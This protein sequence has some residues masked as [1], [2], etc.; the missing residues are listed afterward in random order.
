MRYVAPFA[1]YIHL[2]N[3]LDDYKQ[4]SSLGLAGA[5]KVD[6]INEIFNIL[7]DTIESIFQNL[8]K[9]NNKSA[10]TI[11]NVLKGAYDVFITPYQHADEIHKSEALL[12]FIMEIF[13][14]EGLSYEIQPFVDAENLHIHALALMEA[15]FQLS[16]DIA[17][18]SQLNAANNNTTKEVSAKENKKFIDLPDIQRMLV[19]IK[20]HIYAARAMNFQVKLFEDMSH[21]RLSDN[22]TSNFSEKMI[23]KIENSNAYTDFLSP[24]L[25]GWVNDRALELTSNALQLLS[26][27]DMNMGSDLTRLYRDAGAISICGKTTNE[28]AL[29]FV[30]NKIAM[31]EAEIFRAIIDE[32]TTLCEIHLMHEDEDIS[33]MIDMLDT[34]KDD[35][36]QASEWMY[37]KVHL[38]DQAEEAYAGAK[39]FLHLW[40]MVYAGYCLIKIC[41]DGLD[42]VGSINRE[43]KKIAKYYGDNILVHS[44]AYSFSC[45]RGMETLKA[46]TLWQKK[47]L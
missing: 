24:I 3:H 41:I 46:A 2:L 31:Q 6:N 28:Y 17:K 38:L 36:L 34:A 20:T 8:E 35:L 5:I 44:K 23:H 15:V 18:Q 42:S 43:A 14:I 45:T 25:K 1:D 30:N 13:T 9:N 7:T 12:S 11:T 32:I 37:Q 16:Y 39:P 33:D 10:S 22:E 19:H 27:I 26:T 47:A 40:G 21:L 29:E 4:L